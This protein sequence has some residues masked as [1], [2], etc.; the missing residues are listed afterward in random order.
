MSLHLWNDL[1]S[2][3]LKM[4]LSSWRKLDYRIK[5]LVVELARQQEF[6]CAHCDET[7]ALVIEH[8][9][10]P[11]YGPGGDIKTIYNIRGLACHRCNW[12]IGQY[13]AGQRGEIS[14]WPHVFI[15]VSDE[16]YESYVWEYRS[17]VHPLIEAKLEEEMGSPNY[18]RR[19]RFLQKFDG[20]KEWGGTRRNY[21]WYWGFD[22][23]KDK[24]NGSIRT[25]K[26]FLQML[27]GVMKFVL[28]EFKRNPDFQPPEA[29]FQLMIKVEPLVETIRSIAE[30]RLAAVE[31]N[32]LAK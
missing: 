23:I 6:K 15:C 14:S 22:E 19:R 21:P 5:L 30:A 17:R 32:N 28:E 29:F 11:E 16:R 10:D 31:T 4:K 20:W 1:P 25:P 2:G 9:H 26:Q 3:F 24:K 18:W 12:H 13:E 7:Q 27:V 8:D